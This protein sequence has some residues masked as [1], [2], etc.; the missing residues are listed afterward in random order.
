[1]VEVEN[2]RERALAVILK[3][4]AGRLRSAGAPVSDSADGVVVHLTLPIAVAVALVDVDGA[5]LNGAAHRIVR[6]VEAHRLGAVRWCRIAA[7]DGNAFAERA[8]AAT[9]GE[10]VAGDYDL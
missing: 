2:A 8:P 3:A 4:D 5:A 10:S 6:Y 9:P 7:G 1:M